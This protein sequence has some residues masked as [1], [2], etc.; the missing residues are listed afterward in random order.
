MAHGIIAEQLTNLINSTLINCHLFRLRKKVATVT[1]VIK[2]DDKRS[3]KNYRSIN[4][5]NVFSK[6]FERYILNQM[7]PFFNKIQSRLHLRLIEEWRKCLDKNKVVGA[8]YF[9]GL[10]KSL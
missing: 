6:V 8:Q 1:P 7:M 10:V 2:K 9:D 4:V 3:K 5:L